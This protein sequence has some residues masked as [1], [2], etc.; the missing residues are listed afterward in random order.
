MRLIN[1]AIF[2]LMLSSSPALSQDAGNFPGNSTEP[3]VSAPGNA[4]TSSAAPANATNATVSNG[5]ISNATRAMQDLLTGS[6]NRTAS[7]IPAFYEGTNST[8]CTGNA[9][10]SNTGNGT[11]TMG[12]EQLE[13][14]PDTDAVEGSNQTSAEPDANRQSISGPP[15]VSLETLSAL[16]SQLDVLEVQ[17]KIAAQQ[18]KL[19]ELTVPM[20]PAITATAGKSS[21]KAA[22]KGCRPVWPR[23]VSIQGVDGRL[24]A[25]LVSPDGLQIVT[26]GDKAGPGNIISI[27]PNKVLVRFD[28][29][30]VALKFKE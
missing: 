10:V 16:R 29:R 23:I 6:R 24:S 7:N 20:L 13:N 12:T 22:A 15:Y 11:A 19:Q 4:S 5:T 27:T 8:N 21:K 9:S 3:L 30:D 17:V 26:R 25:T 14:K 1:L 28:G 2:M 18:K